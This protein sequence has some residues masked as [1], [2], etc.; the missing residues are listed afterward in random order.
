MIKKKR[1]KARPW[2]TKVRKTCCVA[3]IILTSLC[4]SLKKDFPG[5]ENQYCVLLTIFFISISK[6]ELY[7]ECCVFSSENYF[8]FK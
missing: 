1:D 3:S 5:T 7:H 2:K 8:Y 4:F 6:I